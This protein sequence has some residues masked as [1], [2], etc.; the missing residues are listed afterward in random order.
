LLDFGNF[1]DDFRRQMQLSSLGSE[2]SRTFVLQALLVDFGWPLCVLALLGLARMLSSMSRPVAVWLAFPVLYLLFL[3]RTTHLW[4]RYL[5]PLTPFVAVLAAYG[6]MV[7]YGWARAVVRTSVARSGVTLL[8]GAA[9]AIPL[10]RVLA[11]D[12]LIARET[13]S[14]TVALSWFENHVPSGTRVAVQSLY[15]RSF[16]NVP[17]VTDKTLERL[18]RVLPTTGPFGRVR[19]E[20]LRA[21]RTRPVYQ[22]VGWDDCAT[23]LTRSGARYVVM[24]D[25]YTKPSPELRAVLSNSRHVMYFAP[26]LP[27]AVSELPGKGVNILPLVPPDISVYELSDDG[28]WSIEAPE[29]EDRPSRSGT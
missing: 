22:D 26:S 29:P 11:W 15:E 12:A 21:W 5:L 20:V 27:A 25:A 9:A 4:G 2:P 14:R 16:D 6:V 10:W 28:V 7:I 19:D 8:V 13:D 17:L 23:T 1:I 24:T 18:E 3:L